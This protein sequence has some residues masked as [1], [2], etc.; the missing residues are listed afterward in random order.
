MATFRRCWLVLV[1]VAAIG[2]WLWLGWLERSYREEPYSLIEDGLYLGSAVSEPP[3]G[4]KAVLNLCAKPDPYSVDASLQE[5]IF[6][7]G[8]EPSLAWLKRTVEFIDSQRRAGVVTYVHCLCGMNR[9]GAVVTAYLMYE[10][11]WSRD[12]ALAFVRS[13]R[14]QVQPNPALMRLLAEWEQSLNDHAPE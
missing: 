12:Q 3:P 13:K 2:V 10:H 14:P 9:S 8:K 5:P 6:E 11:R 7:E 4:T 1:V